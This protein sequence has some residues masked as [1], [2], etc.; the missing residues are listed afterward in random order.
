MFKPSSQFKSSF[1]SIIGW[2]IG[3]AH[4]KAVMLDANGGL[5]HC[6]QLPCPLWRGLNELETAIEAAFSLMQVRPDQALHAVTMT[7]ELVDLFPN[8]H[9]GVCEI[10]KCAVNL[11]GQNTFFYAANNSP[12]NGFVQFKHVAENAAKIASTNWHASARLLAEYVPDALFIDIGSTTSDIIP[13]AHRKV[14]L[15]DCSDASRM[16]QDTLVY[17]GVVRTPIMALGQKVTIDHN[18]VTTEM[19]IA[20]EFF[21]TM[22]DVYRL[23]GELPVENDMAETADG[24]GKSQ[25]ESAR[26]LARMVGYDVEDQPIETWIKLA[27]AFRDLQLKQLKTAIL[28]HLKPDTPIIGAG[29]GSF[30]VKVLSAE[31]GCEYRSLIDILTPNIFKPDILKSDIASN[32]ML[33]ISQQADLEICF[34]AYAVARLGLASQLFKAIPA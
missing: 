5:Q 20:A 11:L 19:N 8:R 3:G 24:K 29:A 1:Q 25:Q 7:G 18:S 32:H 22:A 31:L 13:I 26:R 10:A 2:D 4:L 23:T 27:F 15:Q 34:P 12:N 14:A 21:A 16:Q 9:A 30:L 6:I 33:N 17:T 28:K